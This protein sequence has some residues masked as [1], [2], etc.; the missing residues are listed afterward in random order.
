MPLCVYDMH[1]FSC[2]R[3]IR[4]I[5]ILKA[6]IMSTSMQGL[7]KV[8]QSVAL[9]SATLTVALLPVFFLPVQWATIAH[10]K[11]LL[12]ALGVGIGVAAAAIASLV[13]GD[14]RIPKSIALFTVFLVPL[15]YMASG[16]MRGDAHSFYAVERDTVLASLLWAGALWLAVLGFQSRVRV[17]WAYRAFLILATLITLFQIARLLIGPDLFTFGGALIGPSASVVGSWHDLAIF[18]GFTFIL[19][20][21]FLGSTHAEGTDRIISIATGII[22]FLG[23]A[24]INML[25]VWV[26]ISLTTGAIGAYHVYRFYAQDKKWSVDLLKHTSTALFLGAA[27]LAGLFA[28]AGT[29]LHTVLPTA[30]QVTQ[31][32]VRPSWQGTFDVASAVYRSS[33]AL[34]GSGPNTFVREWGMYKPAGVNETAFWNAD[35]AQG[36]GFIPTSLITLGIFGAIAWLLFLGSFAFEGVRTLMRSASDN[37]VEPIIAGLFGGALY[38]WALHVTYPPGPAIMALAFLVSG[39]AISWAAHSGTIPLIHISTLAGSPRW[40]IFSVTLGF[41]VLGAGMFVTSGLFVRALAADML[42]NK[43]VASFNRTGSLEQ[44]DALLKTSLALYPG[45]DRAHRASVELGLLQLATLAKDANAEDQARVKLLQ[46]TV[47]NAIAHGLAAVESNADDYQNWLTLARAYE[48]LAGAQVEG[49]YERAIDAYQGAVAKNPT[50]PAPH[51]LLARLA[52]LKEDVEG[53]KSQLALAVQK[54]QNFAE[55]YFLLSQIASSAGDVEGAIAAAERAV[56]SAP[57]E[58]VAWFQL[59]ALQYGAQTYDKAVAALEQAVLLNTNYA[60]ALYV[61]S[62]SYAAQGRFEEAAR[63]MELVSAL[64]PDSTD[65]KSLVQQLRTQ[66]TATPAPAVQDVPAVEATEPATAE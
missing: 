2:A 17:L 51:L 12:L 30:L 9:W 13:R 54:K 49:A 61:L 6:V 53:A 5:G 48:Q 47:S 31:V 11:F 58:P 37:S 28:I 4:I 55:A 16:L 14:I 34:F 63:A 65:L 39:L 26:V 42:V 3:I 27:L 66:A 22:A 19:A 33:G 25:D 36:V 57:Q 45:Y 43:S 44:S 15:A 64:N 56:L 24:L 21:S 46:D 7:S 10:A 20:I 32:E 62:L 23:L 1:S 40:K 8:L 35:F 52:L 59:G 38:L 18:L 29:T 60:N 50:N 41:I